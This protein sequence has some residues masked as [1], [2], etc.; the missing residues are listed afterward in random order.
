MVLQQQQHR[1]PRLRAM[2]RIAA[3]AAIL[4]AALAALSASRRGGGGTG[5]AGWRSAASGS[6][7]ARRGR[8]TS[9]S[10]TVGR[11]SNGA[12]RSAGPA[13]MGD[14][15]RY[16]PWDKVDQASDESFPASDPPGYYL[17]G[18]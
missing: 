16:P 8:R 10:A 15:A 6:A 5:R 9:T 18:G 3:G 12:I 1:H 11:G 13:A 7:L 14:P 4:A 17:I 2:M